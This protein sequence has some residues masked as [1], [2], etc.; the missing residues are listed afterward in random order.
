MSGGCDATI[1]SNVPLQH[2]LDR[3]AAESRREIAIVAR[4]RA[5]TLKVPQ[6]D[7]SGL[8]PRQLLQLRARNVR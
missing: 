1:T 2:A 3:F 5:T 6:H 7:V 8:L 4:R